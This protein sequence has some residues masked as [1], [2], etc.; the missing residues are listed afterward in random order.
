V[1]VRGGAVTIDGAEVIDDLEAVNG[2]VHV[3]D[4]VLGFDLAELE[5]VS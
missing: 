3:V 1:T 4:G 2:V 5:G